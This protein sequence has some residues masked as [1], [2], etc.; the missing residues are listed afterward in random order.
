MI[1]SPR[2]MNI[3]VLRVRG[4]ASESLASAPLPL[5]E[6]EE[7]VEKRLEQPILVS[8]A[9]DARA[10]GVYVRT[11]KQNNAA[12]WRHA[13]RSWLC[14]LRDGSNW[15]IGN[16][17]AAVEDLYWCDATSEAREWRV[18]PCDDATHRHFRGSAPAPRLSWN[19]EKADFVCAPCSKLQEE[20]PICLSSLEDAAL[21][22]CGHVACAQCFARA[23]CAL[24]TRDVDAEMRCP[25]CRAPFALAGALHVDSNKPLLEALPKLETDADRAFALSRSNSVSS[26]SSSRPSSSPQ[27]AQ[28]N[29][30]RGRLLQLWHALTTPRRA[31]SATTAGNSPFGALPL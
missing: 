1:E 8:G 4:K 5:D 9:G 6:D 29:N 17:R 27:S 23:R 26:T 13:E 25:L 12:R 15:W 24:R 30:N 31:R 20:C 10:N 3:F 22:P 19:V 11:G 18:C 2:R 28:N 7:D 14:I 16:E 21:T